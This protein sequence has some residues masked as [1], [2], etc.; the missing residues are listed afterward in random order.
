MGLSSFRSEPYSIKTEIGKCSLSPRLGGIMGAASNSFL[1]RKFL[2]QGLWE[3]TNP[4]APFFL[5]RVYSDPKSETV[6]LL[7]GHLER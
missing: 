3:V 6:S 1:S 5:I 2:L 7:Q 4:S